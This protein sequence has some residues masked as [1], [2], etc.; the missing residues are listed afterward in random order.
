MVKFLSA[1]SPKVTVEE[2]CVEEGEPAD[3]EELV[4]VASLSLESSELVIL[5]VLEGCDIALPAP[6]SWLSTELLDKV[7]PVALESDCVLLIDIEA[8]DQSEYFI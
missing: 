1:S 2:S 4:L 8:G 5:V 7:V 3:I 6:V